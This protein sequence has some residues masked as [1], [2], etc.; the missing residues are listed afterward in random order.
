MRMNLESAHE[1]DSEEV[2]RAGKD[3]PVKYLEFYDKNGLKTNVA[4]FEGESDEDALA[5]A[6]AID[7][8]LGNQTTF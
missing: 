3:T 5:R 2:V 8:R 6:R 4:V 1:A 7:E